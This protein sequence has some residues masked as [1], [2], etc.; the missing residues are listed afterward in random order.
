ME[1]SLTKNDEPVVY[2]YSE[3]QDEV[4]NQA[5]EYHRFICLAKGRRA[6]A[7]TGAIQH[8]IE[9]CLDNNLHILWCDTIQANLDT[10]YYRYFLPLLLN[11]KSE[12]YSYTKQSHELELFGSHI[13]FRS[14]ERPQS[15]EG[16]YFDQAVLNE[17]GIILSGARGRQ[18]WYNSVYPMLLDRHG[19]CYIIGTPKG[20][21]A[22]KNEDA[23]YSLFYELYQKGILKEKGWKS[24]QYSSYCNIEMLARQVR[25]SLMNRGIE[26][27][28]AQARQAAIE[29]LNQMAND[30]PFHIRKQEVYGDFIDKSEDPIFHDHWMDIVDTLPHERLW[31]QQIISMDTAFKIGELNDYSAAIVILQTVNGHF[32]I[33]DIMNEKYEF[34]DL[35]RAAKKL[36]AK[37]DNSRYMLIEDKAS[38]ISLLQTL[39]KETDIPIKAIK[40]SKDKLTRAESITTLFEQGRVHLLRGAWNKTYIDQLCSFDGLFETPDDLVDCTSQGLGFLNTKRTAGQSRPITRKVIRS[41]SILRGYD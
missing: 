13:Y 7:T 5:P 14:A 20:L 38:G 4:Y 26:L 2:E 9:I 29:D 32:Y 12:Y 28:M 41:S 34:P 1:I 6:G 17:A 10:L 30:L 18:L 23:D 33:L 39:K 22:K 25:E 24:F 31:R 16:F 21:K 37:Y 40:V 8:L 19:I 27:N 15:L 35:L 3:M 36:Y 11:F